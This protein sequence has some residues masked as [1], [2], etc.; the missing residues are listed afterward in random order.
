MDFLQKKKEEKKKEEKKKEEVWVLG[1]GQKDKP[2]L[3][4][5]RKKM[6][7]QGLYNIY[8]VFMY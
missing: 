3:R 8:A 6:S 4:R 7:L 5:R 2:K 1:S